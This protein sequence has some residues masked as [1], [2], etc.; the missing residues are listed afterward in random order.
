MAPEDA[1]PVSP[2]AMTSRGFSG[3]SRGTARL[4]R[5]TF[6]QIQQWNSTR[7]GAQRETRGARMVKT[8]AV[9]TTTWLI[10]LSA[11]LQANASQHWQAPAIERSMGGASTHL[12]ADGDVNGAGG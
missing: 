4:K 6:A 10:L 8:I 7:F 2:P 11:V 3:I 12:V 5:W 1:A 9:L